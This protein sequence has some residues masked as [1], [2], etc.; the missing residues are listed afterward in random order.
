MLA[1]LCEYANGMDPQ[2]PRPDM[3][4]SMK[5]GAEDRKAIARTKQC[6]IP[7]RRS[8]VWPF[9]LELSLLSV[10][11]ESKAVVGQIRLYSYA[12]ITLV[13]PCMCP[14]A[15]AQRS[16]L[17][18]CPNL[19]PDEEFPTAFTQWGERTTRERD[20]CLSGSRKV[21]LGAWSLQGLE[22]SRATPG[23]RACT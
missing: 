5:S 20:G 15:V 13:L 23:S 7:F 10:L 19:Q 16:K 9:P 2:M 8:T 1:V 11:A 18:S 12:S 21:P 17:P 14:C 22:L 3:H 4:A 6:E